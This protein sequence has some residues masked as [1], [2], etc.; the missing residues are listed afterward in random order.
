MVRGVRL[1]GYVSKHAQN[2]NQ[3]TQ[4]KQGGTAPLPPHPYF[5]DQGGGYFLVCGVIFP[6]ADAYFSCCNARI[7]RVRPPRALTPLQEAT[8]ITACVC[9][10]GTNPL[11]AGLVRASGPARHEPLEGH[12]SLA[13]RHTQRASCF[14]SEPVKTNISPFPAPLVLG[15]GRE[16]RDTAGIPSCLSLQPVQQPG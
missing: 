7:S 11:A 6:T 3:R 2:R 5:V 10:L 15:R 9:V 1:V 13:N 14:L 4:E 8:A 12:P 16:Y